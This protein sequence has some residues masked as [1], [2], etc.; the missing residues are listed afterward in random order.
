VSGFPREPYRTPRHVEPSGDWRLLLD[1]DEIVYDPATGRPRVQRRHSTEEVSLSRYVDRKIAAGEREGVAIQRS[2][3]RMSTDTDGASFVDPA[4]FA[5]VGR[6]PAA[7]S[8]HHPE[9]RHPHR[10]LGRGEGVSP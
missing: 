10:L 9:R 2:L 3:D 8:P 5:G 4:R 6:C 7:Q 1:R